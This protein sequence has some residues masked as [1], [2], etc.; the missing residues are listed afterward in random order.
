MYVLVENICSRMH[1]EVTFIMLESQVVI[2]NVETTD[3]KDLF[4]GVSH[5][6]LL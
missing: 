1:I 4:V 2:H 3:P 6:R 5:V